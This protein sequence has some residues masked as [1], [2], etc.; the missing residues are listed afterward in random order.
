MNIPQLTSALAGHEPDP[1]AVL[2]SLKAKRRRRNRDRGL[3]GA[4]VV[5]VVA[6]AVVVWRPWTPSSP[7]AT[8]PPQE[9]N[10]CASMSLP[11]TLAA[12]VQGGAS[13]ILANGS[14]TSAHVLDDQTYQEMRLHSARTLAGPVMAADTI[15][16]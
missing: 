10:G 4:A 5:L 15:G 12:A 11:D 9:A 7:P 3:L 8:N 13:V 6:V 2:A 16:G 14:L 1:D